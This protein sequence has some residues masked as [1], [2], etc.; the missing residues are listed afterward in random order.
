[1]TPEQIELAERI[2]R[3]IRADGRYPP[4][5]YEFLHRGLD[6]AARLVHGDQPVE[7][8]ARHVTGQQ[9]SEALRVLAI[10]SWGPL[11]RDV[12]ARWNIHSTRD[13]G[14]MVYFMISQQVMGRQDSDRIEDFDDVYPFETAFADYEIRFGEEDHSERHT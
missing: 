11:A 5:A 9:L 13:F 12:F 6:L 2:E 8:K 7:G 14:E 10:E 3:A 4:E 1:M